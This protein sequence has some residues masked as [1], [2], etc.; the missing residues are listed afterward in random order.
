M[1]MCAEIY[2]S[3]ITLSHAQLT[4]SLR[5]DYLGC[6]FFSAMLCFSLPHRYIDVFHDRNLLRTC[7]SNRGLR[8]RIFAHRLCSCYHNLS[9]VAC[10]IF[11][12]RHRKSIPTHGQTEQIRGKSRRNSL[13]AWQSYL[14]TMFERLNLRRMEAEATRVVQGDPSGFLNLGGEPWTML[15]S[16]G[17]HRD[18][19]IGLSV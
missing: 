17:K 14:K 12:N 19:Q 6:C 1:R 8:G 7:V 10:I 11:I 18:L 16:T 15:L 3:N 2:Y 13:L 4:G 9:Y 5:Y